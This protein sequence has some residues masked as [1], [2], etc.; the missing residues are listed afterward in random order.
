MPEKLRVIEL[1]SGI[2]ATRA[3]LDKLEEMY[4]L[5]VEHVAQCELD[6]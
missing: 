4:G 1:F 6:K 3:A 5:E 2:G